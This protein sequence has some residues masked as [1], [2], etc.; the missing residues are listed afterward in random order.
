M[1]ELE[2]KMNLIK[3]PHELNM[4]SLLSCL[5]YGEPGVGKTTLALSAPKPLLIDL[6]KGLHRVERRFHCASL[7]VNNFDEI[8][9]VLG[10]SAIDKYE[11]IVIDTLGKLIDQIGDWVSLHNPKLKQYDGTLT[12]QGWGV[13]KVKFSELLRDMMRL[14]KHLIFVAHSREK[15]GNNGIIIKRPAVSGSAGDDI[16]KE[17][18]L[19]GYMYIRN[20]KRVISFTPDDNYYAKNCFG[21]DPLLEIP[22]QGNNFIKDKLLTTLKE[23]RIANEEM[24]KSYERLVASNEEFIERVNTVEKAN[25]V[26][27]LLLQSHKIW[28]SERCWK[29]RLNS[30]CKEIG[31]TYDKKL[32]RFIAKPSKTETP[33]VYIDPQILVA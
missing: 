24:V 23:K 9:E 19:M 11:S 6:D 4:K 5:I 33:K 2:E 10:S 25:E 32:G 28:D 18:D 14:N 22:A 1:I 13:V 15:D 29:L 12:L 27:D 26:F 21:F 3:E 7:Q 31:A 30:K 17:L 20:K 8:I 16:M